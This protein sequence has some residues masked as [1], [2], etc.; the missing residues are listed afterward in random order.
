VSWFSFYKIPFIKFLEVEVVGRNAQ[1]IDILRANGRKHLTKAEVTQRKKSEIKLGDNKLKCP[2]FIKSDVEA[3]KKWKEITKIYKDIDFVSSGDV[4]LL[5][6]YCM[7]FSEY[8][9]LL[10]N[11]KSVEEFEINW[12]SRWDVMFPLE[13]RDG[14]SRLLK[15]DTVLQLESAINKKM[16]MLIKME[17][18]LF[19]NP[20][21]KVKNVPKKEPEQVDPLAAK[22]FGNI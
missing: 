2:D 9:R 3:F 11:R 10:I 12:D 19:L 6:R 1:P 13:I 17:D 5:A 16:D 8:Q 15:L 7:T 14:I 21:A 4:G 20:L 18:R 22:G